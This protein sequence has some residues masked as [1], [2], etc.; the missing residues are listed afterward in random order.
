V[1][2]LFVRK[3]LRCSYGVLQHI[4]ISRTVCSRPDVD[5]QHHGLH[6]AGANGT[7]QFEFAIS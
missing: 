7:E 1:H 2:P 6:D 5:H 4:V 3:R